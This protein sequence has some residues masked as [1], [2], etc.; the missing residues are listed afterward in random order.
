MTRTWQRNM[1]ASKVLMVRPARFGFN[2][3]TA[4]D[5]AFQRRLDDVSVAESAV[6][7]FDAYVRELE[8]HGIEVVVVQDSECPATPDSV[9]PNNWF[10]THRDGTLV[11]YPICAPNRRQERKPHALDAIRSNFCVRR[12][13]DLTR[14]EKEGKY[15]EGTGSMVLDREMKMAYC[16]RSPRTSEEVLREFC[17]EMGYD[18]I[19]FDAIDA[20][21]TP[22]YHTNVVMSVGT[23]FAVLCG[24]AIAK[25]DE[26]AQVRALLERAGKEV[27]DISL[28]QLAHFAGNIL[29]LE[30]KRGEHF[31]AMS[32]SAY[33]SLTPAQVSVLS[34]FAE[35]LPV[36]IPTIEQIGGGSARCML[37]EV[38]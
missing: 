29:E 5:N 12:L 4:V 32:R 25:P 34:R 19:L 23:S 18:S 14:W 28:G 10:S 9:F 16:S 6:L 15:L 11:L 21:G 31:I 3:E 17:R 1:V 8:R 30:N 2:E 38:W 26:Y 13:I 24:E 27:V 20:H 22:I 33:S 35:L 37:A 36:D 7:E